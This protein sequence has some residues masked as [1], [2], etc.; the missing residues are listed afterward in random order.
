MLARPPPQ[1][2]RYDWKLINKFGGHQFETEREGTPFN[3]VAWHGNYSPYRYD[4]TKFCCI[5]SV[6]FDHPDPS[7]YT[8]LTC[9]GDDVGTATADFV[10]F[11]ERWMVMENTFRPPWYHRNCMSEFMGMVWGKY[12]A[13]EGFQVRNCSKRKRLCW[14]CVDFVRYVRRSSVAKS[15]IRRLYHRYA[16]LIR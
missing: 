2:E 12:D 3:V 8:V 1:E 14:E 6:T 4:L 15:T 7:I 9:K 5:N 11:P 13:K 10:I 16:I